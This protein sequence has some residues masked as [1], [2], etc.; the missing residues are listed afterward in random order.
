L[1]PLSLQAQEFLAHN[2][3]NQVNHL[4]LEAEP[5]PQLVSVGL[6]R[7]LQIRLPPHRQ[8]RAGLG[9]ESLDNSNSN[10]LSHQLLVDLEQPSNHNSRV[11]DCLETHSVAMRLSQPASQH[12]VVSDVICRTLSFIDM[13]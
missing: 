2:P 6:A 4:L 7:Q 11:E 10:S 3:L 8:Q 13:S 12:L 5:R 9:E 1:V